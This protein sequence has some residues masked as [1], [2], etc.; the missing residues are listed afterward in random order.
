MIAAILEERKALVTKVKQI[1]ALLAI[2]SPA[3]ITGGKKAVATD[4]SARARKAW[5]TKKRN[6][7]KAKAAAEAGSGAN[8]LEAVSDVA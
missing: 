6:A 8:L 3:S 7:A 4:A 5:A 1:D 2:F